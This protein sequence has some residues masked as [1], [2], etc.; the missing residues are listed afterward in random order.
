MDAIGE[1]YDGHHEQIFR[2]VWSRVRHKEAAE[3]L[4]GEIFA[5]MVTHLPAYRPQQA[6]FRAWLYQIA[7]NLIVD[8][9]RRSGQQTAVPLQQVNA[10]ANHANPDGLIDRQ[11]SL[12]K[13]QE[14]LERIDSE[15]RDVVLMRFVLGM[16]LEEVA[17][18]L[19]KSVGAVKSIQHRGLKSLRAT[20]KVLES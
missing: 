10:P 6:P 2:Y 11:L 16:S 19:N 13:V 9:F 20:L 12:E 5:R 4:T 14:A 17:E 8:H 18:T 3:D 15:Q 1:L 7:R